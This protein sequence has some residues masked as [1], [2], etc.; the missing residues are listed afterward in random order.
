MKI[1][2]Q[3][4]KGFTVRKGM[5]F[6]VI[7]SEGQQVADLWD[8]SITPDGI[9]WLSTSQTRDITERM[10][11]S[12]GQSFYS[13]RAKPLLTLIENN[14]PSPRDMLFPACN[15]G[16]YERIG[17]YKHPNCRDNLLTALNSEGLS[18]P[19]VPD[20]VN[21]FQRS[22]PLADGRL[23]VLASNNPAGGNVLLRANT[24]LFVVITACSVDYHATNGGRCS[25]IL[26]EVSAR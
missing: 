24:D 6:R 1:G 26:V 10:F 3:S 11:L 8:F 14:S 17:L 21:L 25:P 22:E 7:D 18:L 5:D 16:P 9:D 20:P 19:F 4:G 12:L 13:E 23:E 15:I 2:A